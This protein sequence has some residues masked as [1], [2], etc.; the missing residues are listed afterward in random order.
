MF[1]VLDATVPALPGRR[2]C[3]ADLMRR[4][5]SRKADLVGRCTPASACRLSVALPE[6]S[7]DVRR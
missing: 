1:R 2:M 5:A 7:A 3:R 4:S 6:R